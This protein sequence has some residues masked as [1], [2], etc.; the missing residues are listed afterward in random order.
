M[1]SSKY[2]LLICPCNEY[3]KQKLI[4]SAESDRLLYNEGNVTTIL[5]GNDS[6]IDMFYCDDETLHLVKLKLLV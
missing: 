2:Q 4:N 6:G 3:V 1:S 5:S